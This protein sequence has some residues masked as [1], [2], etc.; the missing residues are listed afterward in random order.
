MTNH[1]TITKNKGVSA[2]LHLPV[3]SL[4]SYLSQICYINYN[5]I[6]LSLTALK[7]NGICVAFSLKFQVIES[8]VT[9]WYRLGRR[10]WMYNWWIQISLS[11]KQS[12]SD[13]WARAL[14]A[15]RPSRLTYTKFRIFTRTIAPSTKPLFSSWPSVLPPAEDRAFLL[16]SKWLFRLDVGRFD[17]M[18]D[19]EISR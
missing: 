5:N 18:L 10:T 8:N 12:V 9:V 1:L 14:S 13:H 15:L 4:A 19:G 16:D 2:K 11:E 6:G 7:I 3:V 17:A